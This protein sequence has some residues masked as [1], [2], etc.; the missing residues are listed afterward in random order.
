[1]T[2]NAPIDTMQPCVQ[3]TQWDRDLA[4]AEAVIPLAF[5]HN[6]A[7]HYAKALRKHPR[8][9]D[10]LFD[11]RELTHPFS[12]VAALAQSRLKSRRSFVKNGE[13]NYR[14]IANDLLD[15]EIAEAFDAHEQGDKAA[16]VSELYDAVAVLM[17]MIAVVEGKQTL[18]GGAK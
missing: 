11:W 10:A 13:R 5:A 14:L 18:G 17:R 7:L 16:T 4:A 2:A 1:M 6:A 3:E 12:G 15:C 9:A 8:F